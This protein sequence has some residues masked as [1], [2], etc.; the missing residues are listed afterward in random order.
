MLRRNGPLSLLFP[1]NHR[2]LHKNYL[3]QQN[4]I[5]SDVLSKIEAANT[6]DEG[7]PR[8]IWI[9]MESS[10]RSQKNGKDVFDLE[11]CYEV[12]TEICQK[13]F[14]KH[15]PFLYGGKA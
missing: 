11:K 10:L 3:L 9:D 12:I 5:L 15:P 14:A 2:L 7:E 1:D 8:P 4:L 6:K 13:G